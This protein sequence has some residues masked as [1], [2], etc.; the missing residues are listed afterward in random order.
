MNKKVTPDKPNGYKFELFFFDC[1][2]MADGIA[3]YEVSRE[4]E[5]AP[6]KNPNGEDSPE[7]ARSLISKLH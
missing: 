6:V 4:E 7:S 5:F 1:F 3:L 2:Y